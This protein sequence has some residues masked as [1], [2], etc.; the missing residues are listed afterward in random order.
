EAH[1]L[2]PGDGHVSFN[3]VV[4]SP[5]GQRLAYLK[6]PEMPWNQ[7]T[8]IESRSLKDR[9]AVTTASFLE[10]ASLYWIQDHSLIFSR[11]EADQRTCNLWQLRVDDRTGRATGGP[12]RLTNWTGVCAV[13]VGASADGKRVSFVKYSGQGSVYSAELRAGGRLLGTPVRLTMN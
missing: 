1:T 5:G 6:L 9:S 12:Q 3:N 8:S 2:E 4:W 7:E 11:L 13:E 10:V